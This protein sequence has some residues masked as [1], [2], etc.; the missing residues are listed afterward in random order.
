MRVGDDEENKGGIRVRDESE[1]PSPRPGRHGIPRIDQ[2]PYIYIT[3]AFTLRH[4]GTTL[5]VR[6]MKVA[7]A[8]AMNKP[9]DSLPARTHT[10]ALDLARSVVS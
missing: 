3:H 9:F 1:F 5:E 10:G 6:N 8:C 2:N 7:G 4:G